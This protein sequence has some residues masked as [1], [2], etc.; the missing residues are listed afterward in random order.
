MPVSTHPLDLS[1]NN[2]GGNNND[3]NS[4][5]HVPANET[6]RR[7]RE[8]VFEWRGYRHASQVLV[9]F[10]YATSFLD[11]VVEPPPQRYTSDERSDTSVQYEIDDDYVDEADKRAHETTAAVRGA[12]YARPEGYCGCWDDTD[13]QK[14]IATNHHAIAPLSRYSRIMREERRAVLQRQ[15]LPRIVYSSLYKNMLNPTLAGKRQTAVQCLNAS[16]SSAV[17]LFTPPFACGPL[18]GRITIVCVGIATE[19]GCFLSGLKRR[20]EF[21]HMYPQSERNN[22]IDMSPVC[23]AT[24][25]IKTTMRNSNQEDSG[26]EKEK[27]EKT[28]DDAGEDDEGEDEDND[29][30]DNDDDEDD[31][32]ED[33]SSADQ[34]DDNDGEN[35]GC[36]C[37]FNPN[38]EMYDTDN[39][40][41]KP[42]DVLHRGER[43]P[44]K[45]HCYV[46]VVDGIHSTIRV[47]GAE[48]T[49]DHLCRDEEKVDRAR[50]LL[51]G[52]T[53]GSDH[54]FDMSLCFGE[55]APGEGEGAIAELAVFQGRLPLPDIEAMEGHLMKKHGISK[56]APGMGLFLQ[57]EDEWKR[58]ARA[59]IEQS[60]PYHMRTEGVPLRVAAKDTSVAWHRTNEVTGE[61][62]QIGRIGSRLSN[63]SSDW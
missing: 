30:E 22:L 6:V 37:P 42:P 43:G 21:G 57:Q 47:D 46:A 9:P 44:G 38:T 51:D 50:V 12:T 7:V 14:Q 2:D 39:D 63:G 1:G 40:E 33:D 61:I 52:L 24:D 18:T 32:D 62:M 26:D 8:A 25:A 54:S 16:G 60:A 27:K 3:D 31:D 59:L 10:G 15:L 20:C 23:I 29:D 13:D 53:I 36:R 58:D 11:S 35:V 48:E 4:N 28:E 49:M 55:G 45:W 5:Y 17:R 56:T 19:D 41:M 34:G